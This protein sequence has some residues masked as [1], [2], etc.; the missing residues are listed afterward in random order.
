MNLTKHQKNRIKK[1]YK[2]IDL[3]ESNRFSFNTYFN[4]VYKNTY[5][6]FK[7]RLQCYLTYKTESDMLFSLLRSGKHYFMKLDNYSNNNDSLDVLRES[8]EYH[9]KEC[10]NNDPKVLK[11]ILIYF[12]EVAKSNN[13]K[14]TVL[15]AKDVIRMIK[16]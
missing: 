12:K 6:H 8:Y 1:V 11:L 7:H 5:K 3:R 14:Y 13:N 2:D 4:S 9:F 10:I 15:A 16:Q